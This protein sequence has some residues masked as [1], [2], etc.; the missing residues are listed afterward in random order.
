MEFVSLTNWACGDGWERVGAEFG[1]VLS[2]KVGRRWVNFG[3][4]VFIKNKRVVVSQRL[5]KKIIYFV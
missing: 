5:C 1:C 4:S 3:W 2:G